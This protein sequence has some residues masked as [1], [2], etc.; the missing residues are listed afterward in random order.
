MGN[1]QHLSLGDGFMRL[2]VVLFEGPFHLFSL[3]FNSGVCF[4]S[5]QF[6][7]QEGVKEGGSRPADTSKQSLYY[8]RPSSHG[9]QIP[10]GQG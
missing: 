9:L 5:E 6:L 3:A 8:F 10:P 2:K 1:C 7:T 4:S